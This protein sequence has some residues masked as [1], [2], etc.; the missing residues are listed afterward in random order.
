MRGALPRWVGLALL[1]LASCSVRHAE[2]PWRARLYLARGEAAVEARQW[3]YAA[4]YFTAA[5]GAHDSPTAQWGQS[6][7][8]RHASTPQWSR[9]FEGS[10][11]AL[12]F[13]GDGQTLASAGFDSVVRLWKADSGELLR[14]F[15]EHTAEVHAVAFSADGQWLASAGRPGEIR[16][17]DVRRGTRV[18]V[19]EG[20]TDVVRGLAFSP[21]GDL[22]AS[23]GLD[24]TVRVWDVATGT[25]RMRF[26]H[27]G[28]ALAVAFSADGRQLLSTSSDRSARV[29]ALE[30]RTEV[31]RLLGHEDEVVSAAFSADG[32][33]LMTAAAD[34]T[35][36]FWSRR[37]GQL[38]DVLR[39]HGDTATA[40][41]PDFQW[42]VQ[43]G[44]DGHVQL[45]DVRRGE[46][47]ERLDAHRSFAMAVAVSPDGRGFASGGRDG[48]LRVWSRPPAPATSVLRGH[49]V[50]VEALAFTREQVL[51]SAGEDGVRQWSLAE[52][53][54]LEPRAFGAEAVTLAVS[55]DRTRIAA[56]TPRGTV[57]VLD[58][59]SGRPLLELSG[60]TG[61]VRAL[62]FAPDGK[63]LAA[64]DTSDILLWSLPSGSLLGRLR[65]HTQKIW[66]LAFDPTGSRLASGAMDKTVR[67]WD[68]E[69]LQPLLQLEVAGGVRALAFTPAERLL[70]TAGMN[71]PIQFWDLTRGR[72]VKVLD[73]ETLGVVSLDVSPDGRF[74]ASG[75]MDLTVKI[76]SLPSGERLGTLRGHQGV[77]TAL[78]FSPDGTA[79]ASAGADRT[80]R[81]LRLEA[82][83]PAPPSPRELEETLRRLG[84]RWE[85]DPFLLQYR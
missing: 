26:E 29:W 53:N 33:R 76:W 67:V 9:R 55:P 10:V 1:L 75:A 65:G 68:V 20:H 85:E 70:V 58:A 44:G 43:A 42:L 78:A 38:L 63:T 83:A 72:R 81:L 82:R 36:R 64:G 3:G 51:L 23:C 6:W 24:K 59:P 13:S 41:D 45:F 14:E 11:L 50:W 22:L 57:R 60:I 34:Q 17:W 4:G 35:I 39:S 77:P 47:L 80:I 5:R 16:L 19:L 15:K 25:E 69:R 21:H 2:Q 49:E 40:I 74:L 66:A 18:A 30:S 27:D 56:G 61:S 71:Q 37:S 73:E 54:V 84:L 48:S 52:G 8:M 62:A 28:H 31:H 46:L 12:A 32:Q 7:A 79:L